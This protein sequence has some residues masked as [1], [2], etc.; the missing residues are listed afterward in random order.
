M[1]FEGNEGASLTFES[2]RGVE[3]AFSHV[4]PV[5]SDPRHNRDACTAVAN[6]D[7]R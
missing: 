7:E 4:S 5:L 2:G 1:D 3:T 6:Y